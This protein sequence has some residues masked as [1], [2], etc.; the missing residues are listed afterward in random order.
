[1]GK[2]AEKNYFFHIDL[3]RFI[4]AVIIVYYHILHANIMSYVTDERYTYLADK[5]NY[6]SNIVVC[7]FIISGLFMYNSYIKRPEGSIFGYVCSRIVR[8]GAVLLTALVAEG[9]LGEFNWQRIILNGMFLQCSGLS[10]EYKGILWYVSSFFF[11]SIFMYGILSIL[12]EKKGMFVIALLTYLSTVFLI[13][14]SNGGIGG[15][16]TIYNVLNLGVLRGV[17]GIGIGILLGFVRN[18]FSSRAADEAGRLRRGIEYAVQGV[19]EAGALYFC[20]IYF[21][22]SYRVSNHLILVIIFCVLLYSM[23]SRGSVMGLVFNR[24]ALGYLGRYAYAIYVM[25]QT[26]FYLLRK[27]IWQIPAFTDRVIPCLVISTVL[28]V[29]LGVATY[30]VVEKPV[31]ALYGRW[32]RK[33]PV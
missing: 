7:F 1:M 2:S 21:L 8:L 19:V 23:I 4:F 14:Y 32:S 15:R 28:V 13:N 31:S 20:G 24:K 29:L 26:G 10:L 18:K 25:Q 6:A 22:R 5:C 16:E 12:K 33:N 30:H 17:S 9:I 3:L 27:T 11:A